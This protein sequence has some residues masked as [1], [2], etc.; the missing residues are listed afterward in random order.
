MPD[1]DLR[2]RIGSFE[3]RPPLQRDGRPAHGAFWG[4]GRVVRF[5]SFGPGVPVTVRNPLGR[6]PHRLDGFTIADAASF[7]AE[8][9][10]H[11]TLRIIP[12]ETPAGGIVTAILE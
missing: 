12:R 3:W 11:K 4:R 6:S 9:Q 10:N 1:Q 2:A 5:L 7:D 8:G